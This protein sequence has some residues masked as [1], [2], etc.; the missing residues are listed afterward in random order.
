M[1]KRRYK[2]RTG[3]QQGEDAADLAML[4]LGIT[5]VCGVVYWI[6]VALGLWV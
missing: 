3:L 4:I 2:V 1:K 5:V 6:G